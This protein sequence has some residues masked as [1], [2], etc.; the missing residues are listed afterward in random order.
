MG[1]YLCVYDPQAVPAGKPRSRF[2]SHPRGEEIG[3]CA[4][5]SVAACHVHGARRAQFECA[6]CEPGRATESVLLSQAEASPS[7]ASA[8]A[9]AHSVGAAAA[10]GGQDRVRRALELIDRHARERGREGGEEFLATSSS[11]RRPNLLTNLAGVIR[12]QD[13]PLRGEE[14]ELGLIPKV[15]RERR[16]GESPEDAVSIEEISAAVAATFGRA[17][18]E[19]PHTDTAVEVV[20]GAV[21]LAMSTA[22]ARNPAHTPGSYPAELAEVEVL[23]PW[24]VTHPV[25]LDPVM[26]MVLT[27]YQLA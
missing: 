11:E 5:C 24:S 27:A 21:L 4:R 22:D 1:C 19:F 6:I 7:A 15:Q 8:A 10:G 2:F 9:L 23:P 26:W 20:H 3:T 14:A 17:E 16:S 12:G 18:A 13:A 25:L